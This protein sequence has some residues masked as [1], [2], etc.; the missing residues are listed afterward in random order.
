MQRISRLAPPLVHTASKTTAAK[1]EWASV[2]RCKHTPPLDLEIRLWP[3]AKK[4]FNLTRQSRI[5]P[6][7]RVYPLFVCPFKDRVVDIL[8]PIRPG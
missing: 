3:V 7:R 6:S 1:A 8:R 2:S 4:R 5:R